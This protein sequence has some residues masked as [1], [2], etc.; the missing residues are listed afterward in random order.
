MQFGDGFGESDSAA[1]SLALSQD[2]KSVV[3]GHLNQGKI[4]VYKPRFPCFNSLLEAKL[5]TNGVDNIPFFCSWATIGQGGYSCSIYE[6]SHLIA[7][8]LV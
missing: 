5:E 1:R 4:R 7:P 6:S 3:E 2:G 8:K